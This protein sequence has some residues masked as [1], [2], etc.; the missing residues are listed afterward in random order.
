MLELP[1]IYQLV[2]ESHNKLGTKGWTIKFRPWKIVY[3][4][5]FENKKDALAKEKWFK[6]GAGREFISREILKK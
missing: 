4:E 6:S 5:E 1:E 3:T 2:F